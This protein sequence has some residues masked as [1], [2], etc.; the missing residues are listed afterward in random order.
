ML[1]HALD[2]SGFGATW[3]VI[4]S[5]SPRLARWPLR[6]SQL[7]VQCTRGEALLARLNIPFLRYTDLSAVTMP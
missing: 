4:E 5:M 6:P 1:G 7:A 3:R 2:A